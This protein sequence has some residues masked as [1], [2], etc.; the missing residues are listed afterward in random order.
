MLMVICAVS[1]GKSAEGGKSGKVDETPVNSTPLPE[2][3]GEAPATEAPKE[4]EAPQTT[5][6]PASTET[7]Q[8][9]KTTAPAPKLVNVVY[10]KNV[11]TD[12]NEKSETVGDP[13]AIVDGDETTRWSGF[14]LGRPY[15]NTNL[16]HE[17]TIDLGGRYELKDFYI[18][19][20][21][22]TGTY[23][24]L[25][26]EDGNE[27]KTA[28]EYDNFTTKAGALIDEGDLPKDTFAAVIKI[29]ADLPEGES[30]EGYPYC[31]IYEFEVYGCEAAVQE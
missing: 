3:T 16:K 24:I 28:Y 20:E 27:W 31:S 13:A 7:A 14:D 11:V 9:E 17:I 19:W 12:Y 21:T 1:C 25:V 8:P 23:S 30:F 10:E 22:L 2:E 6:E 15:W 5:D 18:I 29:V 4:T 26:S